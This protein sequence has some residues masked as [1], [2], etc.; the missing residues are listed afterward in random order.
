MHIKL[1]QHQAEMSILV[2]QSIQ[3]ANNATEEVRA[4]CKSIILFD[5]QPLIHNWWFHSSS[6]NWRLHNL[7]TG[8]LCIIATWASAKVNHFG[9]KMNIWFERDGSWKNNWIFFLFFFRVPSSVDLLILHRFNLNL[10][11]L[12]TH[13]QSAV[14][15]LFVS[16]SANPPSICTQVHS[17]RKSLKTL[18]ISLIWSVKLEKLPLNL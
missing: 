11:D 7:H 8:H 14:R 5:C 13:F 12:L 2:L 4:A 1:Q 16:E 18:P 17:I 6:Y 3:T 9:S 10:V 15:S